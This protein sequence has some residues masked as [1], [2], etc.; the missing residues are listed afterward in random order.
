MSQD[1]P[2]S[3]DEPFPQ[4]LDEYFAECDEHLSIIRRC[5]L[6]L[7]GQS[8]APAVTGVVVDELFRSFHTLKGISAMVGLQA[9]EELAHSTESFLRAIRGGAADLTAE[10]V[11]AL[12]ASAG[13]LEEVIA[14]RQAGGEAPDVAPA[15]ARLEALAGGAGAGQVAGENRP[16]APAPP[17]QQEGLRAYR[18][19]FTPSPELSRRGVNV[20]SVRARLREL[21]ELVRAAPIMK[22]QGQIAF[23]FVVATEADESAFA[24]WADEG[25]AFTPVEV[26]AAPSR[27]DAGA[28]AA[29]TR[30]AA[31]TILA[32]SNVV[33]VDLA[34]L[35]E[36]M[37]VVG[38]LVIHRT[39]LAEQLRR[40]EASLPGA[41]LRALQEASTGIE[42]GLRGLREG[43]MRVR[44]VPV[45]EIFDRMRFVVRDLAREYRKQ[46]RLDLRGHE[47]E[48]DKYLVE[49]M[50]GPLLHLVRNAI[51]HGLE[52][53]D[54]REAAGK[55]P[56]G[57]LTLS[58]ATAG[59]EVVIEVEDDGRGIDVER[60]TER[61][62][63]LGLVDAGVRLDAATLLDVLCAPGF[64]TREEADRGSGR[65]VGMDVVRRAAQELGG[66]LSV[67]TEQRRGTRFS[68]RL[69]LTLAIADALIVE[70]GGERFAVPQSSVR[71]VVEVE[72]GAVKVL[73]NN[74]VIPFRG[75][76]LPLVRLSRVFG[77][78]ERPGRTLHTFVVGDGESAVGI[79][80]DRVLGLREIVVRAVRDPLVQ[81]PGIAGATE[82]GD[83]RAVLILEVNALIRAR[84][85]AAAQA[86]ER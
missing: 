16:G 33:R 26:D 45:A 62:R 14:A 21:G 80:V 70:V 25:L 6:T 57:R 73:E 39:R 56:E 12:F 32:P 27:P 35:D 84:A 68:V 1:N 41:E 38:E 4:L 64:S 34:R 77:L 52:A 79:A 86:G 75:A 11:E 67:E 15:V 28:A 50:M 8:D 47:T 23:E 37:R 48:I 83:G 29:S 9:A 81:V 10:G 40:L 71:E 58:A 85:Q 17:Q 13:T 44:M 5:L 74:E 76:A 54:E 2:E 72:P 55:A 31:A 18:V 49:R 7:E 51:S 65:G 66:T 78:E 42:H 22:E 59:E 30:S 24:G 36:L 63:S 61:A 46:V 69:P 43:I 3:Y 60:V 19:E 82:L 20:D 53:P